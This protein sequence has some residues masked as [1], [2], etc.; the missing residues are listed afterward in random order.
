M[1]ISPFAQ[2]GGFPFSTGFGPTSTP[3]GFSNSSFGFPGVQG[4]GFPPPFVDPFVFFA[5]AAS[6]FNLNRLLGAANGTAV[7]INFGPTPSTLGISPFL[8]GFPFF[9]GGAGGTGLGGQGGGQP[10][11]FGGGF[12]S[13]A[14]G[15]ASQ[16]GGFGGQQLGGFGAPQQFG[17]FGGQQQFGAQQL[18]GA[19]GQQGL[20]SQLQSLVGLLTG[21]LGNLR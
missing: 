2:G 8:L 19:A 4:F 21:L 12:G 7:P 17:Q 11:P 18:G 1:G 13:G 16:F 9:G 14:L 5:P 20:A 10:S 15:G 6:S 3:G